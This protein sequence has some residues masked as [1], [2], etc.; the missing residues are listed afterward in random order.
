MEQFEVPPM[1]APSRQLCVSEQES[2]SGSSPCRLSVTRDACVCSLNKVR[3]M[4]I[5]TCGAVYGDMQD[6]DE[7]LI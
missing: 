5:A 7:Q 3:R 4:V 6:Y 1:Y 2:M